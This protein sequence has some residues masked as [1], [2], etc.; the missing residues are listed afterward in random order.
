M[1]ESQQVS[2]IH[3]DDRIEE[4]GI[5]YLDLFQIFLTILAFL[6]VAIVSI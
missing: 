5:N 1:N 2:D 4:I 6:F 3:E